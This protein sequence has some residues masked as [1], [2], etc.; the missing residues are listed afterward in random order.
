MSITEEIR[1]AAGLE[2]VDET[3]WG[4]DDILAGRH[5]GSAPAGRLDPK[6]RKDQWPEIANCTGEI[7][8]K[9]L[10][11]VKAVKGRDLKAVI[12]L[13]KGIEAKAKEVQAAAAKEER[14]P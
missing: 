6:P 11:L 4:A 14:T 5:R 10:K 8:G 13:A 12:A 9:L 2:P 3:R 7:H 1:Q